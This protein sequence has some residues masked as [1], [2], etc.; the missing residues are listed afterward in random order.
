MEL[1]CSSSF[2]VPS[3]RARE[4]TFNV[5][6]LWC[7]F[8]QELKTGRQLGYQWETKNCLSLS[9]WTSPTIFAEMD[10]T[11]TQM[12]KSPCPRQSWVVPLGY[13][14]YMRTTLCR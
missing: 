3:V 4:V 2:L 10:Q 5:R 8:L 1:A 6:K 12:L 7:E 14:G 11:F 13:K 9:E